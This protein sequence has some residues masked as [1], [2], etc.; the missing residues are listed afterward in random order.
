MRA[1]FERLVDAL[2][3]PIARQFDM[4]PPK[5]AHNVLNML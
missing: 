2:I 3:G 5:V 1:F 4:L